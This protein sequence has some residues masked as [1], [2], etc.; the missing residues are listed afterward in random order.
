MPQIDGNYE[1][2]ENDLA[3]FNI[4][5]PVHISNRNQFINPMKTAL[6]NPGG[7]PK[8]S[9]IQKK[10]N[11]ITVK[12]S[13]K[14]F[15]NISSELPTVLNLNPRS[16]YNRTE[17]FSNLIS[18]YNVDVCGI[19]ESWERE[20]Q[21]L[22]E[23]IKIDQFR[24]LKNVVQRQKRGGKPAL[25]INEKKYHIKELCPNIITVP[26]GVEAVWALIRPKKRQKN[27]KINWIT[28]CAYY[29]PE[30]NQTARNLIYDHMYESINF[31]KTKYPKSH[32]ILIADSNRLD[33]SPILQLSSYFK[34]VVN[35]PT[36]LN[37]PATLDT[38]ITD[39]SVYY[40]PP[41][42][43]PPINSDIIGGKPSDHLIVLFRPKISHSV[44]AQRK[45]NTVEFRPLPESGLARYGEW[46]MQQDWSALYVSTDI[47]FKAEYLQNN[48]LNKYRE[49]FPIKYFKT[50]DDDQ[51]WFNDKLKSL[52][53]SRKRE[54]FKNQKSEKWKK[55]NLCFLEELKKSKESYRQKMVD[56]LKNTN[57]SKWY[58]KFKRMAGVQKGQNS[59]IFVEEICDLS[60]VEQANQIVNF[61]A[62]TRNLYQRVEHED[63]PDFMDLQNQ[64]FPENFVTPE[65]IAE[66]IKKLNQKSATIFDDVPM[67]I[68]NLFSNYISSP[69]CNIINSIFE[70]GSYP[71]I[72]KREVITPV[73][74]IHP[75]PTVSKLRPISGLLNFAKVADR[76]VAD[77][78]TFDISESGN[79]DNYQYGN[80]KGLSVNH[81]LINMIN[82]ILCSVDK[83]SAN[84]KVAAILSMIDWSQAFE[85]QSH[86]LGIE[87]FIRNGVR[88]SLIPVLISFFQDRQIMV[89]W[90]KTVSKTLTVNGGGPQ[91]GNA[92]IVEYISQT[93]GNL[94]FTERDSAFKFVD[95]GSTI[96]IIN[97]LLVGLSTFNHKLQIPSDMAVGQNY[98]PAENLETQSN[99]DKISEWTQGQQMKLN[100]EKTKYMIVNF[101]KT[102]QFQTRIYLENS[103]LEQVNQTKLLGVVISDDLTWHQNTKTIVHKAYTRIIMLR[104][105]CEFKVN[106]NDLIQIY[107]LYIRSVVEQSCVVWGSAITEQEKLDIERI[108]KTSLKIIY[109]ADYISYEN[110]LTLSKLPSL[111]ERRAKLMLKFALKCVKNERTATMFPKS[112][113]N[114]TTRN[115]EQYEVPYARTE[116]YRQSAIPTMARLLNECEKNH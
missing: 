18:Q 106:I 107:I 17:E 63:F 83:N 58:S 90:N 73:P 101:C 20:S 2:F 12:R 75:A 28:V 15:F 39:L 100:S 66:V 62:A 45:Y 65:K 49:I 71:S 37:P 51:P 110:A 115:K 85:R 99:L 94:D 35:I 6:Q 40:N 4:P 77:L 3:N 86:H 43:K 19:S 21:P 76:L 56:D 42:T 93:T 23:I 26:I 11:N 10:T 29:Y 74:K 88:P 32:T 64:N 60:N 30:D 5:I 34:Q 98:I 91:G 47:N 95:D 14:P 69:L 27:S 79:K 82:K 116:R 54:F 109:K 52:D 8:N 33:L 103:L 61:F 1:L 104:K 48:L 84:D 59:D 36:R 22:E 114:R 108:Q 97:L 53:R 92:G 72:W 89:K 31:I 24:V 68:I 105:L 102:T 9:K 44:P 16:I 112:R 81:Y 111:T 13:N 46:L 50:T 78:I 80:E 7:V 96:E 67:K 25:V 57:P 70:I 55:V 41:V 38:I 87:S 113:A